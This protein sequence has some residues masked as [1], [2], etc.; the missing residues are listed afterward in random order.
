VAHKLE[1]RPVLFKKIKE[2]REYRVA[3]GVRATRS[4]LARALNVKED[5]LLGKI[6]ESVEKPKPF[7]IVDATPCQEVVEDEVVLRKIPVLT[8]FERDGGLVHPV[9]AEQERDGSLS[10]NERGMWKP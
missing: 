1:G 5:R 9:Q 2:S 6:L 3:T 10:H 4:L 7:R 8:H